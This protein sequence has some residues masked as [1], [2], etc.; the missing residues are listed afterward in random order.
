MVRFLSTLLLLKALTKIDAF[1]TQTTTQCVN[2]TFSADIADREV[3]FSGSIIGPSPTITILP[4]GTE[5]EGYDAVDTQVTY[6]FEKE[7]KGIETS[8]TWGISETEYET[9]TRYCNATI[10]SWQRIPWKEIYEDCATCI[11]CSDET[12]EAD[13]T[14][15]EQGRKVECGETQV[16]YMDEYSYP[17]FPFLASKAAV[18]PAVASSA[19]I[20]I[21]SLIIV[22]VAL[23]LSIVGGQS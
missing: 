13:C 12:V 10:R 22:A 18:E 5:I 20:R 23:A 17:F 19:L 4:N 7:F 6:V 2:F 14:N 11:V 8:V 15:L 3:C 1:A 21:P 9:A 16:D